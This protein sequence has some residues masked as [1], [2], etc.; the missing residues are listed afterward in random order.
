MG[1]AGSRLPVWI[2]SSGPGKQERPAHTGERRPSAPNEPVSSWPPGLPNRASCPSGT[3]L[4]LIDVGPAEPGL[5]QDV[6]SVCRRPEHL[7]GDC[8]EQAAMGDER[9]LGHAADTTPQLSR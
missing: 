9:V 8:E 1:W 4:G 5:L 7:I 3:R 6:L 2:V